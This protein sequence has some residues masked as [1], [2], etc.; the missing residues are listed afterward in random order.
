MQH[1]VC[2]KHCHDCS[3]TDFKLGHIWDHLHY[4]AAKIQQYLKVSQ[5]CQPYTL[6]ELDGQNKV[7]FSGKIEVL[8]LLQSALSFGLRVS[9]A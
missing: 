3:A 5:A 8:L 9:T 2:Y 6:I 7:G 4:S 1:E